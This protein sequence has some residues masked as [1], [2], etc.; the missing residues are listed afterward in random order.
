MNVV[1]RSVARRVPSGRPP[2]RVPCLV[3]T[4]ARSEVTVVG[5]A[6]RVTR[7]PQRRDRA[8]DD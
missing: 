8:P 4:A 2:M 3:A 1:V 7:H 5:I 6:A